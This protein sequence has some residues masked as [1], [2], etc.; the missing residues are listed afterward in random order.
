M[1]KQQLALQAITVN[2]YALQN[3]DIE[4]ALLENIAKLSQR[5]NAQVVRMEDMEHQH[6]LWLNKVA[7]LAEI[8][9]TTAQAIAEK[10]GTKTY[11]FHIR[12]T[13][14]HQYQRYLNSSVRNELYIQF[15]WFLQTYYN[16]ATA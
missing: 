12:D 11:S 6:V 16:D 14:E 9:A 5:A 1:N 10:I 13:S 4:K 3:I 8:N 15:Q 2:E 7:P